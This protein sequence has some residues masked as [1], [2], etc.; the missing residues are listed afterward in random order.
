MKYYKLLYKR[1]RIHTCI[2]VWVLKRWHLRS[3]LESL[4]KHM[5]LTREKL[6]FLGK[7]RLIQKRW[8]RYVQ[9][10]K[11]KYQ[12]ALKLQSIYRMR[13][14]QNQNLPLLFGLV[15]AK[16]PNNPQNN[17]QVLPRLFFLKHQ[18]DL[19]RSLSMFRFFQKI[20]Q[21]KEFAIR[22]NLNESSLYHR[23][24]SFLS[25]IRTSYHLVR[26]MQ[27][28]KS[29]SGSI[30]QNYAQRRLVETKFNLKPKLEPKR[31]HWKHKRKTM[32]QVIDYIE[33]LDEKNELIAVTFDS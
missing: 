31:A 15:D 14:A 32:D 29:Q 4:I 13:R 26:V 5:G 23:K 7:V 8:R 3:K 28:G 1:K 30:I 6:K 27:K 19:L 24:S 33:T 2:L 18:V 22:R 25:L 11:I 16:K 21:V 17:S 20:E 10:K 9:V 12:T